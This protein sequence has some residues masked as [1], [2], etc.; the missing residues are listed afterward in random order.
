[1]TPFFFL[2]KPK[3][4]WAAKQIQIFVKG[5][6]HLVSKIIF[7][8]LVNKRPVISCEEKKELKRKKKKQ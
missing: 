3:A 8:N 2:L 5:A 1:M 4:C 7:R 6:M